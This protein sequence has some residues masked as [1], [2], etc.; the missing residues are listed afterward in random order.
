MAINDEIKAVLDNPAS[1]E[2][3][4]RSLEQALC[5]DSV[6]AAN[7]VDVL[8]DLLTR[9]CDEKL[10]SAAGSTGVADARS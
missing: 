5:R 8:H 2:W 10:Q 3:L 6:D 1:S 9:R 7:D 4:K